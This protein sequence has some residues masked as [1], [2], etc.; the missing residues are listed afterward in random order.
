MKC[1]KLLVRKVTH[2]GQADN[3]T[4]RELAKI[5]QDYLNSIPGLTAEINADQLYNMDETLVYVD[6]LSSFTIDFVKK[7]LIQITVVP[8]KLA[9]LLYC[10]LMLLEEC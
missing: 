10:V 4:V 7:T 8:L 2:I 9:L 5:A 1:N 6:M 3:K